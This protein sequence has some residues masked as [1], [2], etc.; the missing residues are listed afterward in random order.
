M[1]QESPGDGRDF[2]YGIV[3][4]TRRKRRAAAVTG[5]LSR[6][7]RVRM[8]PW[9]SSLTKPGPVA[10]VVPMAVQMVIQVCVRSPVDS[11]V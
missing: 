7:V 2:H 9:L 10:G 3:T 5:T 1:G 11:T 4:R 8:S 6:T